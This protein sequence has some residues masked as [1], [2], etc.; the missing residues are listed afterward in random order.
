MAVHLPIVDQFLREQQDLRAALRFSSA[1]SAL[2]QQEARTYGE[3]IPLTAPRPGEQYAFHVDL[4][5][6]SGCKACVVACNKLNGLDPGEGFRA[7]GTIVGGARG[8]PVVQTV[9]AACHHCVDPACAKGCPVGAYEKDAATGIVRHLDDQCI[10]CQ[11]CT[12]TCPYEVPK[13]NARLGIVRKCDMCSGRLAEGEAPACVQSCPNGAITIRV[14]DQA[15]ALADAQA[16]TFLPG[17]PSPGL[18]VPTTTYTSKRPLPRDALPVDFYA[19]R[20]AAHHLPLV[21]MLVL[22]QLAVGAYLVDWVLR[23]L[24]PEAQDAALHRAHS[25]TALALA[26]LA[27]GAATLHLGRPLYA[28]RAVLGLRTSWMSREIVAFGVFA[29]LAVLDAALSVAPDFWERTGVPAALGASVDGLT[30]GVAAAASVTGLVGLGCSAMI[31]IVTGK[32]FWSA[33]STGLRF[34]GTTAVLGLAVAASL[35]LLGG[36][37]WAGSLAVSA[38]AFLLGKV[39]CE[40]GVLT[41]LLDKQQGPLKRTALLVVGELRPVALGRLALG[42]FG[43]AVLVAATRG[44][45]TT[46]SI[47]V[48]VAALCLLT[49]G[50][51]LERSLFFTALSSP[52][53]PGGLR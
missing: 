15:Q 27:L 43:A 23:A 10:G 37:P 50:E 39:L 45:S 19:V 32:A 31:Y 28:F 8:A 30:R 47:V 22:T 9:T 3:L 33:A 18:T 46:A 13:Y 40:A 51:L 7:V 16:D 12:L 21:V 42:V 35:A 6:C 48:A 2:K 36:A 44:P 14:V 11:Y 4:D 34:L 25:L 41:H 20:P 52:R 17:A 29:K 1:H 5:A 38:G 53:M 26:V 49:F 24:R